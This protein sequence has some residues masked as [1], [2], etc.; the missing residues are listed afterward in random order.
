MGARRA[1][2]VHNR[3]ALSLVEL[4]LVLAITAI[5][6][7]VAV[8]RYGEAIARYQVEM[9]ARRVVADLA[10]ARSRARISSTQQSVTF[11]PATNEYQIPGLPDL[12]N[13]SVDYLANLSARP[14]RADLV[15]ANFGPDATVVF[16]GYGKP[17]SA[18]QVV[19]RVGDMQKTIVLDP[20]TGKATVQ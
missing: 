1:N 19:V 16:D 10:L 2:A 6:A 17:D 20:D 15:S 14:Y 11:T 5:L 3:K 9:A 18:G 13:S 12:R 8:P 4:V 7:A